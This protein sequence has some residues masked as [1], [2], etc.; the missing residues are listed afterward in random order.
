[1]IGLGIAA[2]LCAVTFMVHIF[3]GTGEVRGPL[4]QSGM[5]EAPRATLF[6]SWHVT[7]ILLGTMAIAFAWAAL[8]AAAWE[9]GALAALGST[10][11]AVLSLLHWRRSSLPFTDLPQCSAFAAMSVAALLGLFRVP[12]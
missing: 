12:V 2:V 4:A 10:L 6:L 8:D 1:M 7:S 11:C 9:A 5:A 3:V